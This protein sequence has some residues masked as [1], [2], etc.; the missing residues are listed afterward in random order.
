MNAHNGKQRFKER[1]REWADRL[2]AEIKS[3]IADLQQRPAYADL[4]E[5]VNQ[6][7]LLMP[8]KHVPI[9]EQIVPSSLDSPAFHGTQAMVHRDVFRFFK[10]S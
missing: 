6:L 1:V 4:I 5:K 9:R 7:E 10:V 2:E 3:L 8:Y